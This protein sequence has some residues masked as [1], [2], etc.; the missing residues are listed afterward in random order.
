[1]SDELDVVAD[2]GA[3]EGSKKFVSERGPFAIN[4]NPPITAPVA[5]ELVGPKTAYIFGLK[6]LADKVGKEAAREKI[7]ET[8]R[9]FVPG[10]CTTDLF[11]QEGPTG[12]SLAHIWFGPN[13]PL[14]R[15]S[16]PG[17]GDC[18]YYV[19]GG[20]VIL[21]KR[22]LG[23]GSTIFIPNGQ[24]YK[25]TAGPAGV[26]LLEF[27]AGGGTSGEPGLQLDE[28]SLEALQRITDAC[29]ENEH[30]W[31]A[32][33]RIGDTVFRQAEFDSRVDSRE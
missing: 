10:T 18:L 5:R 29:H 12:M 24:P 20:E 1:M 28:T 26:E 16:H 15:H 32:P 7:V 6:P 11:R 30:L 14:Y 22:T 21:G 2:L 27:R 4:A 31:Q 9:A 19:V 17:L 13:F 8:V 3:A 23:I 33:E 25:Y